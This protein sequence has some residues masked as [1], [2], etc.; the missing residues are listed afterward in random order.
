MSHTHFLHFTNELVWCSVLSLGVRNEKK[1]DFGKIKIGM[2]I[3]TNGPLFQTDSLL[4]L[5]IYV[6]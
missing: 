2:L 3:G 6:A 4:N 5:A 1:K